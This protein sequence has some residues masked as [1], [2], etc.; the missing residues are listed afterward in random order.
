MM[1]VQSLST[2]VVGWVAHPASEKETTISAGNKTR[3][4]MGNELADCLV[5]GRENDLDS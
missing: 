3:T 1:A 5:R 2:S 4:L